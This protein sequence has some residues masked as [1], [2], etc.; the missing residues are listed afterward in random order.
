M[1][2]KGSGKK[3]RDAKPTSTAQKGASRPATGG[4]SKPNTKVAGGDKAG[5][6]KSPEKTAKKQLQKRLGRDPTAEEVAKQ[7]KKNKKKEAD[8][9]ARISFDAGV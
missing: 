8:R 7:I 5:K 1:D 2:P 6:A 9:A 4:K 3:A